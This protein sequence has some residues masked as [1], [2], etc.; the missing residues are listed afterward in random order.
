MKLFNIRKKKNI[1]NLHRLFSLIYIIANFSRMKKE[2]K[3]CAVKFWTTRN[4]WKIQKHR[5]LFKVKDFS[6][7]YKEPVPHKDFTFVDKKNW[8]Y[9]FFYNR[10]HVDLKRKK[11]FEKDGN[12]ISWY[13]KSMLFHHNLFLVFP[14]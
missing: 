8:N 1:K 11:K 10:Y 2:L 12:L 5:K 3:S 4:W 14:T 9:I 7:S 13:R 6:L